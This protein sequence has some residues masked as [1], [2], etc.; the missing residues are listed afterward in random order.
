MIQPFLADM[1]MFSWRGRD[2]VTPKHVANLRML[3][4]VKANSYN[5]HDSVNCNT[6]QQCHLCSVM[7]LINSL[8]VTN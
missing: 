6:C 8:C 7:H 2:A 4:Q 3:R 5:N 1:F